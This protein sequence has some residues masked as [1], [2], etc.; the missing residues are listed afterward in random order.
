MARYN[1]EFLV[2][3]LQDICALYMADR[4]IQNDIYEKEDKIR[5][6]QRER[7]VPAPREPNYESGSIGCFGYLALG[8][9]LLGVANILMLILKPGE[10]DSGFTAFMY[11]CGLISAALGGFFFWRFCKE[12]RD[13]R[14]DNDIK[15][16]IYQEELKQYKADC[17]QA[18]EDYRRYKTH[19]PF[20]QKEIETLK[21]E[22]ND[23]EKLLTKVY[24]ANVIPSHYR[25]IYAAVYLY[26]WFSTSASDD[27]DHAL[28]MFVLEEIKAKLDMIIEQQSEMIM[29]QRIIQ[30]NQMK[31]MELQQKHNHMMRLKL[32]QL[33]ITA[34]EQYRYVQMIE[35]NTAAT[36]YFAAANYLKN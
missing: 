35:A 2:P 24:G 26:D 32:D 22:K 4:K 21:S 29:N 33:Q 31:S 36:A 16:E 13:E 23:L 6:Y 8:V 3:Y 9:C 20:I 15:W 11:I 12:A 17:K 34:E 7:F 30:A 1:R 27:L 14:E 19:I 5:E 18:K 10:Y 25:N 28:S